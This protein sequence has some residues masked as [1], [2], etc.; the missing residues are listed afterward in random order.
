MGK[1]RL[2]PYFLFQK[3][4]KMSLVARDKALINNWY[5][6][7]L[8]HELPANKPIS[9]I[10]YDQS[11]VLFRDVN[12]KPVA[13]TDRCLHRGTLLSEGQIQQGCLQCPYHGWTYGPEGQVVKVP[14][15]GPEP[16]SAPRKEKQKSFPVFEADG[17]VWV[18]MGEQSPT[19]TPFRFPHSA[20][21][22][23]TRYFMV[24][25]FENEVTALVENFMDVP[26]TVF[27]HRG[28][29]RSPKS[30]KVPIVVDT[31]KSQVL[32]TYHQPSDSIGFTQMLFN[33]KKHPMVHT[34]CFISPNVTKVD[35]TFG[36]STGFTIISQCTPVSTLKTRVY[37]AII[38][39]MGIFSKPL[40]PFIQ[41]YTRQVINQ[42]VV[43]MRHQAQSIRRHG[44]LP[45]ISTSA[46]IVH[47]AIE[48]LR[49][50]AINGNPL[51]NEFSKKSETE[52]W[53]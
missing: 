13:L 43:I 21:K 40:K 42:D 19:S 7:C 31:Q 24:T 10:I 11:L 34:D 26:H 41:F 53:I 1:L 32:V 6:A 16:R 28:W 12:K 8:S 3:V 25:D 30:K 36:T 9:R 45:F 4:F 18:W 47:L 33:P 14:S 50:F 29:F 52:I 20:D 46:D 37:T 38:Y 17:C 44:E 49:D 27:V 39:K 22:T 5:I 23:W 35:Y 15:R 48:K 51:L 2:S